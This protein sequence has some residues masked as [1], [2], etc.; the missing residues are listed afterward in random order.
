MALAYLIA[1]LPLWVESG[2]TNVFFSALLAGLW[3]ASATTAS[4]ATFTA[5]MLDSQGKPLADAVV[6]L[7]GP[8]GAAPAVLQASMDQRD[9]EF[10]P[11]VLAVHTG[12]Q[13]KFPNSDNIRHQ[14]YSFSPAKRFELRLY[15]G[16]PSEPLLFDKPGVVVLGCNIHD[17]MVGYIYVTDE[18][19]FGVTDS[20]GLL[21]L[22]QI[23]AGHYAAT[24][25]HPQL[26]NMQPVSGGEFEVPAAGLVQ[27]FK[28]E[29]EA[30]AED[31][32]ARP[33][34]SGFGDAFHKAA[35]E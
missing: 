20:K 5:Q 17:W 12:T 13:V 34:S 6:T 9:Q 19:W 28:L 15:E 31:K 22:D 4:A 24:L 29:V 1:A 2:M 23:P 3:I 18:P 32:P 30:K 16:T 26:E 7:K 25:W 35:H 21:K 11:Y 10:S 8:A 14:V 27:R 33:E